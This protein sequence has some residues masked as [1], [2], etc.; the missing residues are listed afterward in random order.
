MVSKRL[1]YFSPRDSLMKDC[2]YSDE[3]EA[4][5]KPFQSLQAVGGITLS[6][7]KRVGDLLTINGFNYTLNK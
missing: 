6:E 4:L 5:E 1:V 7:T 2:S 3:F